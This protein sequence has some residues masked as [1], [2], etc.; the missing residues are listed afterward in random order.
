MIVVRKRSFERQGHL[1]LA[2]SAAEGSSWRQALLDAGYK[3]QVVPPGE[4][5]GQWLTKATPLRARV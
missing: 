5:D 4:P 1:W 3:A 2:V